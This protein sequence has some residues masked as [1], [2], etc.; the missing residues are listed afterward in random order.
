MPGKG[1]VQSR[2]LRVTVYAAAADSPEVPLKAA[3]G[4]NYRMGAYGARLARLVAGK[5]EKETVRGSISDEQP[6]IAL[7]A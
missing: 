3:T 7:L 4:T 6:E 5:A 1:R 2:R